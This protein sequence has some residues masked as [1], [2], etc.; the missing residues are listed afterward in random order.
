M[1]KTGNQITFIERLGP[2]C[3]LGA[4]DYQWLVLKAVGAA[5]A[6]HPGWQGLRWDAIGFIAHDKKALLRCIEDK[7]LKLSAVGKAALARQADKIYRWRR[8][9]DA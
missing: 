7:G 9:A 2:E 6:R 8:A 3:A 4:D 5:D 1:S